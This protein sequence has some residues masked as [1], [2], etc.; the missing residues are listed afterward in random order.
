VQATLPVAEIVELL[1]AL[2][3]GEAIEAAARSS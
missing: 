1:P 3:R 2:A